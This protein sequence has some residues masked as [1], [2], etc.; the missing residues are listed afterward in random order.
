MENPLDENSNY[1]DPSSVSPNSTAM[2]Y[3]LIW[4]LA[5]I[6]LG[7]VAHVL[8]W[9]NPATPNVMGSMIIGIA[10]LALGIT[11]IVLAIKQHREEL[12][13]YISFGRAF[14]TGF[15]TALVSALIATVW[16]LIYTNVVAPDMFNGMEEM[17]VEQWEEQGLS[18]EQIEQA[19]GMTGMFTGAVGMTI[20]TFVGGLIWGAILSLITGAIMKKDPPH[21][22]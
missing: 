4:G 15:F 11:M 18:D 5:S 16:M 7:L 22:A 9:N 14:K 3:G 1:I 12:G 20:M 8:G 2:R 10:S 13:G 19:K 21:M 6:V 17:M